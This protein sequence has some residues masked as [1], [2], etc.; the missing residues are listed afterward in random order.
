MRALRPIWLMVPLLNMAQ[1]ILLKQSAIDADRAGGT[2][3]VDI[4][5]SHWFL[6][7]IVAE[8]VCFAIWMTVLSELDLSKAFP[9]SAISYVLIMGVAWIV[10]DEPLPPLRLAGSL[11]ILAGVWLIATA[12]RPAG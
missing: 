7:A 2:W 1:Q 12:S 9:L 3:L 11:L 5:S 6:A 4:L 10:F 8:I